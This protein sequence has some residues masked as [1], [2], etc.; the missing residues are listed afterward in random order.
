MHEQTKRWIE[1][2]LDPQGKWYGRPWSN[3][4]PQAAQDSM[5]VPEMQAALD[6]AEPE[7][8]LW[9]EVQNATDVDEWEP[10]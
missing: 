10:A 6:D 3:R 2:A 5:R 7:A 8:D 9:P 1:A 4:P